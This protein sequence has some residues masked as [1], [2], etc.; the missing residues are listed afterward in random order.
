[1]KNVTGWYPGG[2]PVLNT[3]AAI[4]EYLETI[5]V[6]LLKQKNVEDYLRKRIK[7]LEDEHY[8]DDALREMTLKLAQVRAD[9]RRGFSISEQEEQAISAWKREH[10]A[11]VHPGKRYGAIGG[12]Y[13]YGFYPT[14][15]GE[16]GN[17]YCSA[18]RNKA[19]AEAGVKWH[20]RLKEL[21]GV[22][23]FSDL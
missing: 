15:I 5:K 11:T 12:G 21:G 2:V 10:E 19:I 9:A 13:E 3:E 18:C 8:K 17:C 23:N 6:N 14:S 7:E 1:V 20:E 22:F 4:D 16:I